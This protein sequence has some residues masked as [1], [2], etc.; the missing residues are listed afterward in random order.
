MV[1]AQNGLKDNPSFDW[2]G[3]T[4]PPTRRG[5]KGRGGNGKTFNFF[6]N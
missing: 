4:N 1:W 3:Y 2:M 6:Y 5:E